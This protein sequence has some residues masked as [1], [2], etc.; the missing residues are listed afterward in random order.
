MMWRINRE[1]VLLVGGRA[2]L[3][4]QLA[5]PLV[6]AGVDHHSRFQSDPL[7]R[8]RRTMEAVHEI[9]FADETTAQ[10]RVQAINAIHD[11]VRG[12]SSEG[13]AYSGRDP[14]LLLWV[15]STLV[16]ASVR[17]YESFVEQ[18]SVAD[19]AR[20]YEETRVVG[21]MFGIPGD[22][23]P[24]SLGDLRA[25]MHEQIVSGEVVVTPTAQ[26]LA[27]PL[28]LP[29][30]LVPGRFAKLTGLLA[31]ALLP[32]PIRDGYG[33]AVGPLPGLAW[34]AAGRAFRSL[35][36]LIPDAVATFPAA[37]RA[38]VRVKGPPGAPDRVPPDP[39]TLVAGCRPRQQTSAQVVAEPE[40]RTPA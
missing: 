16:D 12:V 22:I 21:T 5:H 25:W 37:R 38:A 26:R 29:L 36:P 17:V 40:N 3:L 32:T 24:S 19:G 15:Y 30:P 9:V 1:A 13:R 8:L 35:R 28:L 4:M 14:K 18:L 6:A 20:Y 27:R 11:R 33:L 31:A 10:A 39:P 2:A 34:S 23:M 7:G